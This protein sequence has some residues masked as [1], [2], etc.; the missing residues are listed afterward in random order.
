MLEKHNSVHHT[1]YPGSTQRRLGTQASKNKIPCIRQ[2][3][4][5]LWVLIH[6]WYFLYHVT[7]CVRASWVGRLSCLCSSSITVHGHSGHSV[8]VW[9]LLHRSPSTNLGNILFFLLSFKSKFLNLWILV[10]QYHDKRPA[11]PASAHFWWEHLNPL[12]EGMC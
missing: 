8:K 2:A 7:F 3:G 11:L 1:R 6:S 12:I 10:F 4:E 5:R 9:E